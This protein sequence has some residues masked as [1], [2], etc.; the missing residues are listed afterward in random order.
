MIGPYASETMPF[1]SDINGEISVPYDKGTTSP[2]I[3]LPLGWQWCN[4][5]WKVDSSNTFGLTDNDGWS[6]GTTFE[7]LVDSSLKRKL[8]GEMGRLSIVRRRRWVRKMSSIT[9]DAKKDFE[10]RLNWA[11]EIRKKL[12]KVISRKASD[13]SLVSEYEFKRRATFDRILFAAESQLSDTSQMLEGITDKLNLMKQF[14][15]E[16]GAIERDYSKRIGALASKWMYAGQEAGTNNTVVVK[17]NPGFFYS[18]STM[19][20]GVADRLQEFSGLLTDSLPS[21]E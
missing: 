6:Y 9:A 19:S 1:Y 2:V 21:G 3:T 10:T 13:Y 8:E 17:K 12:E 11:K 18:V 4:E 15:I 16:R 5:N 20:V 7:N 14:L